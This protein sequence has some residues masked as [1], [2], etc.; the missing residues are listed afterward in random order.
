MLQREGQGR[1]EAKGSSLVLGLRAHAAVQHER[2]N[3]AGPARRCSLA[4][5]AWAA[6]RW[7]HAAAMEKVG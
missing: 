7:P 4:P 1:D 2:G 5:E 6:T 3:A